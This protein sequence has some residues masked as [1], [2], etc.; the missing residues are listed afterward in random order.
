MLHYT[1]PPI[2]GGVEGVI[3]HHARLLAGAGYQVGV[4]AGRGAAFCV[5]VDLHSVP[6]LDSRHPEVLAV[7]RELDRGF[8]SARFH[9]LGARIAEA[10]RPHLA[11]ADVLMTHNVLTLHKNLALTAALHRLLVEEGPPPYRT[12]AWHHDLAWRAPQ[13][14]AEVHPGYPWDLLRQVW[15]G[16]VNVTISQPRQAELAALYGIPTGSVA[17]VPPG[18]DPARFCRWSETT[19]RIVR[20]CRLL[21][22]DLVLL[23][24]ARITRRKNVQLAMRA[25]AAL[26]SQTELDA[27][28]VVT[29]PPGPHNPANA[30][31]LEEL[32]A[33]RSELGLAQSVHL[34]YALD[35]QQRLVPDQATMTDLYLL[36]DALIL[37]SL[38]EGFGIPVLEA[39]LARLPV[40]C[41]GLASLQATGGMEAHYFAPD[42]APEIVAALI[43]EWLLKDRAFCLRRRIL[44][45]YLWEQILERRLLPLLEGRQPGAP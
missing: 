11:A 13:Y 6:E 39:G 38:E 18:V 34:L 12:L 1:A 24:P 25:L 42:A 20:A 4:L 21:D 19:G 26:R 28:L 43:A 7:K 2:V 8:V 44:K 14:A 45:Q 27:R 35:A 9:Q 30:T 33:L 17:V 15:P 22:A 31:Y 32:L 40:F 3:Y 37:P 10:L 16:V 5:G 29:G 36:A 23:L 41:T